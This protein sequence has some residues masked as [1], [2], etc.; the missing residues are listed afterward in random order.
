MWCICN[1]DVEVVTVAAMEVEKEEERWW[2]CRCCS[3]RL[4]V[5]ASHF[6]SSWGDRMWM[7]AGGI[8][9]LEVCSYSESLF[10]HGMHLCL[11]AAGLNTQATLLFSN[12]HFIICSPCLPSLF[13][14]HISFFCHF[15]STVH[16]SFPTLES[17]FFGS[18]TSLF[19]HHP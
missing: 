2:C 18:L 6:L 8:F 5:Y 14:F 4:Q 16:L 11:C 1:T 7:F 15:H 9:L 12:L 17:Y 10:T 3:E 19:A 13:F